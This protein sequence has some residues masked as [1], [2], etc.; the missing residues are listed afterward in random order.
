MLWALPAVLLPLIIHLLNRLR[1]KTVLWAAMMFLFKANKAATRR[2]KIRQYLLLASRMLLLLFFL[3]AMARPLT[4][5]WLGAAAGG[6]PDTV[7]ILLDRSS[8]MEATGPDRQESKRAHALSLLAQAAKQSEGSHFVLIENALRQP[9]DIADAGTL[10]AMSMAGPS[11]STADIPAMLLTALEYLIKNTP[12]SAEIWL[13]SDLQSS[14]WRPE[15]PD[16]ADL[17]ARFAGLPQETRLRVLDLSAPL[18]SNAS[19][20]LRSV[21]LRPHPTDKNQGH[22]PSHGRNTHEAH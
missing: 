6:A 12:G 10:S 4:G 20:T 2:A 5:G 13:A 18:T 15:S 16:W 19:L 7:I 9:M 3:W 14:N 8:S 21:E 11:D 17:Q 22:G 1:Y